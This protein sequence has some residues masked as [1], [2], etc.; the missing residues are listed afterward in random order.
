MI[1]NHPA[2][3]YLGYI[4]GP[5]FVL[6]VFDEGLHVHAKGPVRMRRPLPNELP[7]AQAACMGVLMAEF[8]PLMAADVGWN[9]VNVNSCWCAW[10][11]RTSTPRTAGPPWMRCWPR[12]SPHWRSR[13]AKLPA[14]MNSG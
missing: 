8:D 3:H 11:T 9:P 7:Q 1:E 12:Q 10:A 14:H 5:R 13:S 4:D 6:Y 2:F